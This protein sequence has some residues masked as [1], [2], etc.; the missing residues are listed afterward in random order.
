MEKTLTLGKIEGKR[1]G[2]QRMRLLDSI[3]DS[4]DTNLSKVR[5]TVTVVPGVLQS[6]GSQRAGH[7]LAT[8]QEE[9][10]TRTSR[11]MFQSYRCPVTRDSDFTMLK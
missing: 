2:E 3:T 11:E 5:E 6:M 4:M 9:A 7:D 8:E 1:T 10:L